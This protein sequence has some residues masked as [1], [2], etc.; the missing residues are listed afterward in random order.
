MAVIMFYFEI[1]IQNSSNDYPNVCKDSKTTRDN[2]LM[3][4]N[5]QF[6]YQTVFALFV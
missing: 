6:N 1:M 3:D 5:D 2:Y 4:T